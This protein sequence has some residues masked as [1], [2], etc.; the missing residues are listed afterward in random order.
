M[1]V[2]K[3]SISFIAWLARRGHSDD[4]IHRIYAASDK[5]RVAHK[6]FWLTMES[7]WFFKE[8]RGN[9]QGSTGQEDSGDRS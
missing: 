4:F 3:G 6:R 2:G 8:T 1:A 5:N 9:A 7:E